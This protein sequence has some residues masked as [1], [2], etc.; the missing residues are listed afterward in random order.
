MS[1]ITCAILMLLMRATV[2][3]LDY[4]LADASQPSVIQIDGSGRVTSNIEPELDER[5]LLLDMMRQARRKNEP[6]IIMAPVQL[7]YNAVSSQDAIPRVTYDSRYQQERSCFVTTNICDKN[8][9]KLIQKSLQWTVQR[10]MVKNGLKQALVP[11]FEELT[12]KM[13]EAYD[14]PSSEARKYQED[15]HGYVSVFLDRI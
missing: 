15:L 1:L 11:I 2:C 14:L 6:T 5:R 4:I 9:D 10:S 3:E 7:P 8:Q 13:T 12:R